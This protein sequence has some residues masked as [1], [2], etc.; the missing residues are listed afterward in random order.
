MYDLVMMVI[1]GN[2]KEAVNEKPLPVPRKKPQ[3]ETLV[4][5]NRSQNVAIAKRKLTMSS[6]EIKEAITR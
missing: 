1:L 2:M 3:K 6:D 5:P 4:D